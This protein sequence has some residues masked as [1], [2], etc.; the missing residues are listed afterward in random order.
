MAIYGLYIF[1]AVEGIINPPPEA[2]A[3]VSLNSSLGII[4]R[5][6][7]VMML[8]LSLGGIVLLLQ[9]PSPPTQDHGRQ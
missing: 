8:V 7:R 5:V 9:K 6:G 4:L 2:L 3:S 1:L